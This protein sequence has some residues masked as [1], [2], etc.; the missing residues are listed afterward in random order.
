MSRIKIQFF[1]GSDPDPSTFFFCASDKIQIS[2]HLGWVSVCFCLS[3]CLSVSLSLSLFL[4]RFSFHVSNSYKESMSVHAYSLVVVYCIT[5]SNRSRCADRRRKSSWTTPLCL[6]L[7][8]YLSVCRSVSLPLACPI[9]ESM[10]VQCTCVQLGCNV[11][12]NHI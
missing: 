1:G 12:Y 4:S 9:Q 2:L 11:L 7:F 8:V 6:C 5:P 10:S 3:V